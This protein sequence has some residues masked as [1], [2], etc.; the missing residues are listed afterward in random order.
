VSMLPL[1]PHPPLVMF[2]PSLALLCVLFEILAIWH[3]L[4]INK[5]IRFLILTLFLLSTIASYY[6]GFYGAD[7]ATKLAPEL[8]KAHQGYARFGLIV[9]MANYFI[10]AIALVSPYSNKFLEWSYRVVLLVVVGTIIFTSHLGG[11]LVFRHGG[12]V[13]GIGYDK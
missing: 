6:S 3:P 10:G 4:L 7:Y 9:L 1:N 8:L 13:D 12:G 5:N 11:D 2:T